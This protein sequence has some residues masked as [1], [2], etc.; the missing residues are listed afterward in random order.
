MVG[1]TDGPSLT[2]LALKMVESYLDM[3]GTTEIFE[4]IQPYRKMVHSCLKM[5]VVGKMTNFDL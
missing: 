1:I 5:V 2:L 3:V 4:I